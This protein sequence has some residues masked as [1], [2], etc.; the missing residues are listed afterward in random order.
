MR[1]LWSRLSAAAEGERVFQAPGEV[2][3]DPGQCFEL[4]LHLGFQGDELGF[5]AAL[6]LFGEGLEGFSFAL[7]GLLAEAWP[8]SR[9]RTSS[10]SC[11]WRFSWRRWSQRRRIS[12]KAALPP[13]AARPVLTRSTSSLMREGLMIFRR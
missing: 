8:S 9:I 7:V 6:A 11:S 4:R 5:V 3:V 10:W 13:R 12:R 1:W 2:F